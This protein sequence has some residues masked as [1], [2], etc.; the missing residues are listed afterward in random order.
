MK[1][2]EIYLEVKEKKKKKKNKITI[3]LALILA[4]PSAVEASSN[5]ESI[6]IAFDSKSFSLF[7]SFEAC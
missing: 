4:L 3:F 7:L 2:K 6:I 5:N 1:R